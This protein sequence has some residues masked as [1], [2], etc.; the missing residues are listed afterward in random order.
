MYREALVMSE[1]LCA[2]AKISFT[3]ASFFSQSL[4]IWLT[5]LLSTLSV[6][7]GRAEAAVA[8]AV[9]MQCFVQ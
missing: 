6:D 4:V 3:N 9:P 7:A 8:G 5:S 2:V 1:A